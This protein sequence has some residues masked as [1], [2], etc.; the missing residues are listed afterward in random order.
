MKNL[1]INLQGDEINIQGM[2]TQETV[3]EAVNEC[4]SLLSSNQKVKINLSGVIR[5]D[6]ASLAFLTALMRLAKKKKTQLSFIHPPKQ[7]ISLCK[8]SGIDSIL[9]ICT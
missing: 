1:Y 7:M 5:C 8:V 9:P 3:M 4:D 2:L 6:S